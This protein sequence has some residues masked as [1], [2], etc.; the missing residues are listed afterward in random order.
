M[1][2]W[3]PSVAEDRVWCMS[4]LRRGIITDKWLPEEQQKEKSEKL[5][6]EQKEKADKQEKETAAKQKRKSKA[7]A[8]AQAYLRKMSSGE[9]KKWAEVE[10]HVNLIYSHIYLWLCLS[11]SVES[12]G[13][14]GCKKQSANNPYD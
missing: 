6:A 3:R 11:S 8:K 13:Y 9:L 2:K 10:R 12:H 7:E 14:D 4:V 5:Q 1:Q